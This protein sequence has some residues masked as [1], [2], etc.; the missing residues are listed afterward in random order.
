MAAPTRTDELSHSL[1]R[2]GFVRPT[3]AARHLAACALDGEALRRVIA[4]C[5]DAPDPDLA[6]TQL[7]RWIAMS[8]RVPSSAF[9][10]RISA[11]LGLSTSLGAFL[12]RH[13]EHAD[14]LR[15]A[16]AL[17]KPRTRK[18]ATDQALRAVHG[19]DDPATALR[20]W[21]RREILRVACRDLAGGASVEEVAREL[22]FLAEGALRAALASLEEEHPAPAGACFTVIGMGKL[23]GEELNYASDI[24]VMFVF[25]G[26]D[27]RAAHPWALA[28][29]E[30]I[31]Q[32]LAATTEEGQVFRV[33][34][35]LRPEGRDGPLVRSI[36]GF[37]QY[38]ERWAKPWEFQALIKARPVAGDHGLGRRF[39]E[40]IEPHVY[41]AGL[42]PEAIREIRGMKA[43]AERA[44]AA[45]GVAHREVKRGPGGIR[46]IEFAVQL[47]Q[48]VHARRDTSLRSG[49]TLEALTALAHGAY[50]G[51]DD[52]AD[53]AGAYRLLRKIEHRLQLAQERQT[54][55]VPEDEAR[56]RT[57]ARSLGFR[58]SPTQTALEAFEDEW[59]RTQALVRRIHEKLFYRP[60][61]ERFAQAPALNPDAAQE[62][63]SALGFKSPGRS[64][65]FLG[66][67]TS[68]LSRRAQLMR[69][70]LPVMLD[71]MADAPDPDLAVSSFRDVALRVGSNPASLAALRD[72]PPVVELLCRV[73]G[74]SRMLGEYLLHVPDMVSALSEPRTLSRK[75]RE[76]LHAEA[77]ENVEWRGD[78][79]ARDAAIRRLKRREVLRVACRDLAGGASV[80]DVGRELAYLAEGALRAALSSLEEE[81]A[82]PT[83]ARFAVIGLGK[84][85]GEELNYA[86]DLDVMFVFDAPDERSGYAWATAMAE[87]LL[88]RLA[89]I[90]E[91]GQAFRVDASLRPEGKDGPLVR[92]LASYRAYYERWAQPW[93][94][95]ALIKARP[96]AGDPT[97]GQQFSDLVRPWVYPEQ[98]G[99][100]AIREIRSIKARIE[101]ERL[102][103]RE[104]PKFQLKVGRGG[105]ID[106]EFT[107]QLLQLMHGHRDP[108]LRAQS[109][110]PATAAAAD[111]ALLDLE[112]ARWMVD[113][114]RFLNRTRNVLYLI[115]GRPQDALPPTPEEQEVLARALGYAAPGARVQ[116]IEDYRRV[117]RRSRQVCE[118][119]FYGRG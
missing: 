97:L 38:Y 59:R 49:N 61:L 2:A 70:L 44:L 8:G 47:L 63:L 119:V 66:D 29:A 19:S 45:R 79:E 62:R 84:L 1:A 43:R 83:G 71:W 76:Q 72:A 112:K 14:V 46:D 109:T 48:L 51:D 32:R 101:K 118:D 30:G 96:V 78:P 93:E 9:L 69:T 41:P 116:F 17:A 89:A 100:D 117:T 7:C 57:L 27:E 22:S 108:R 18:G 5:A 115:R 95:Q 75:T 60:L 31:L 15:D 113:A 86:S 90:T 82:P 54:H 21:K 34:A 74:T 37:R 87:G 55:T 77:I 99:A 20:V 67:L 3:D 68:G 73:L 25:D 36:A 103:P 10:E 85:G 39:E 13:P 11:V 98:L 80:E 16:G 50:V 94:F 6:A 12:A 23:G 33:D 102:G 28:V 26:P 110:I 105:L 91:E 58:D 4:A 104:D 81:H 42:S 114:Y 88:Q 65:K 106:V 52:A 24:D 92:S 40:L 111:M 107:I 64:L 56:R 35:S 53:L